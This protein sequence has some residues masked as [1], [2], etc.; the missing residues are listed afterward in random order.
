MI[1]P[2]SIIPLETDSKRPEI[3]QRP[4]A[5]RCCLPLMANATLGFP[6]LLLVRQEHRLG[7][8]IRQLHVV[9]AENLCGF[10]A[11]SCQ[12]PADA[13]KCPEG[14]IA[15]Q[16][17]AAPCQRSLSRVAAYLV[18][19]VR[20]SVLLWQQFFRSKPCVSIGADAILKL[21]WAGDMRPGPQHRVLEPPR[22]PADDDNAPERSPYRNPSIIMR[23]ASINQLATILF[24][25]HGTPEPS[26]DVC[27]LWVRTVFSRTDLV[28]P[29]GRSFPNNHIRIVCLPARLDG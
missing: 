20:T 23:R 15:G 21:P 24:A 8:N 19:T 7:L 29:P 9:E 12:T 14:T 5:R 27:L 16:A 28:K 25:A 11:R 3:H 1:R 13:V 10:A 17:S 6:W 18:L 4:Y 22:R 26:R 2:Q